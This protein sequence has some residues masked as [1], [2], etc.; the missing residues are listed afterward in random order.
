MNALDQVVVNQG[1]VLVLF[2]QG[3]S[4]VVKAVKNQI[5]RYTNQCVQY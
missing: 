2:V 5:G 4:I 1:G 3:N